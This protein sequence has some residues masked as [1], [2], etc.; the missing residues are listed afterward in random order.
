M[1]QFVL[2]ILEPLVTFVILL[3][4]VLGFVSGGLIGGFFRML[5]SPGAMLMGAPRFEFSVG[6]GTAFAV[7]FH[8]CILVLAALPSGTSWI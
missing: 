2:A 3:N 7:C 6:W 5:S 8:Y 1:R 4:T